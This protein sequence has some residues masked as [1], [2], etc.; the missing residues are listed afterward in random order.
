M[1]SRHRVWISVIFLHLFVFLE[2]ALQV[3]DGKRTPVIGSV[4]PAVFV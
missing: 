4:A 1:H 3:Q 2:E